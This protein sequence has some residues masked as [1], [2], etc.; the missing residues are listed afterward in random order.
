MTRVLA[1][2]TLPSGL[3]LTE[4]EQAMLD[5]E[6][7]EAT[8]LAMRILSR[9][10]PLY[11]ATSLL[12][13]TRAH[14]DGCIYEGD[15][16]LEFAERL[17]SLGGWVRV[18][19]S[20]NVVS[21]DHRHWQQLGLTE[22]YADKARRLGR[23]YLDMGA[24]PTFTCAPYQTAA[25]PSFGEQIAWSESNAVAFANSV[26][27]ARTNRYGDYLDISCALTA[28]V[29]AAG[30]HLS[31]NRLGEVLIR[32]RDISIDLMARDDFYPV[33]GYLLGTLVDD[34]IAVV[35][36]L[37]ASP[38]EDQLKALA[39]AAATSGSVALFHLVG[40]TPE[41]PT[42]DDAFGGRTPLRVA[43]VGPQDLLRARRALSTATCDVVD[44]VAFGSP[45]CSLTECRHLVA[46]MSGRRAAPSVDVF[47]TTSRAVRDLLERSGELQALLDFG[48]KV[49][50]DTCIV[51]AP[52]VRPGT[53]VMVTNSGKYA[54][55]APGLI[56][57][58]A[59]F[60]STE[61]CVAS[62][63]AGRVVIED[64]PWGA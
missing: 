5:G 52:L 61:S 25:A 22:A 3:A 36:G 45:H 64:G 54:H 17:A 4:E 6:L 53:R 41:A 31:Q 42:T 55:Y 1:D 19:T 48:A 14:I 23:A 56:G 47:I 50:A 46:L 59:I 27:G 20:L 18:P 11:G 13:V 39:A 43:D 40:I 29:P 8:R 63:E 21:L 30:L 33:L 24:S 34:E 16:G 28:R 7:G 32:L 9:M 49:T 37:D 26:I 57:V 12:P 2:L 44:L 51:V 62:A 38:T 58:Q 10:A 35:E 60:A 15:A